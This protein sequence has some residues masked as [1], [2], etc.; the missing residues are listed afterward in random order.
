MKMTLRNVRDCG[1]V[2]VE[3]LPHP[4]QLATDP[5]PSRRFSPSGL[6]AQPQ[7]RLSGASSTDHAQSETMKRT[8]LYPRRDNV[9]Y[10]VNRRARMNVKTFRRSGEDWPGPSHRNSGLLQTEPQTLPLK[11][12]RRPPQKIPPLRERLLRARSPSWTVTTMTTT[13]TT[14]A[15]EK[16]CQPN[17]AILE[18]RV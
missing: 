6:T 13:M 17:R 14:G 10:E 7:C 9:E 5:Q 4:R 11:Q 8:L 16:Q 15:R 12:R 3:D 1:S 2:F 18:R